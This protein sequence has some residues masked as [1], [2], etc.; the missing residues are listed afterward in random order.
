M[1]QKPFH[2]GESL[3]TAPSEKA[4]FK[5][6]AERLLDLQPDCS[7]IDLDDPVTQQNIPVQSDLAIWL[8]TWHILV[9]AFG[10]SDNANAGIF[11]ARDLL[12]ELSMQFKS[13]LFSADCSKPPLDQFGSPSKSLEIIFRE[14][15]CYTEIKPVAIYRGRKVF[16]G[17][18]PTRTI[19]L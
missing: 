2:N 11:K 3:P 14:S 6:F 13:M 8:D 1:T 7:I 5:A 17:S 18:K 10:F 9:G 15:T 4:A 12:D 16:L 19:S